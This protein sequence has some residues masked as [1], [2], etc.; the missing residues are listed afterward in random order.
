MHQRWDVS[1]LENEKG[2]KYIKQIEDNILLS[3]N[4]NVEEEWL[5]MKNI[6]TK[7][8]EENLGIRK[9]NTSKKPWVTSEMLKKMDE[10]KSWKN[11]KTPEGKRMYKKLNN[12]L[13]RETDK[14]RDKWITEQC[15]EIEKLNKM[16]RS[17]L[18]YAKAKELGKKYKTNKNRASSIKDKNGKLLK[19]PDE[20]K[21]R[22][23][24]YIEDLYD[25]HNKPTA[26]NLESFEEVCE[27]DRGLPILQSETNFSL[28]K[29]KHR[30]APALDNIP[31]E[32]LTCLGPNARRAFNKLDNNIYDSGHWPKEFCVSKVVTIPKKCNTKNCE[33][34]RTLSLIPHSSKIL[35]KTLY[36]RIYTKVET[37]LGNDQ[38]GFRRKM[39]TREAIATLRVIAEKTIEFGKS[40]YICFVD[41]EKAFDRVNWVKLMEVLKMI[42]L[43]WKERRAVWELYVNQSAV[44]Q[45]GD[46]LSEPAKIGRGARQGGLLSTIIFNI[47]VQFMINEALEDNDDGI[48]ISGECTPA[49]RFADD[50]AMTSHSNSGLQRIMNDLNAIGKMYGMKI[51][52]DKTKVMRITHT[53]QRHIKITIDGQKVEVVTEFKYLGSMITNDGRCTTE[54]NHRIGRAKAAFYEN[55]KLLTS[56]ADINMRK[57]FIK[58]VVWSNALY[59]AETWTLNKEHLM[60]LE[61]FEMW[62]WRHMLKIKWQDKVRNDQ[63]LTLAAEERKLIA[64]IRERQKRWIGHILRGDSLLKL[65]IE[66]RYIG[67]TKRGRKRTTLLSYLQQGES[68]F[69]LKRRAEDRNAWRCWT[70]HE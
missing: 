62:C 25:A 49:V 6:I 26:C 48:F 14:A 69:L 1:N 39:G 55:E 43:D 34:H 3:Q 16:G 58:T 15:N 40:L 52:Q 17:D 59:A 44:I 19:E 42:G 63:V 22:W 56:N 13:R 12:E 7:S 21:K 20:I 57:Q 37:F 9:A 28:A 65:A 54:I 32:L 47:Y 8:A 4:V 67:K 45:V 18:M 66:G 41:Y 31:G 35:L 68:Y 29:L 36:E 46:D 30:K 50:K 5:H 33:E 24:E 11:V 61:A 2:D 23:R 70:P 27:D 53:T 51:N 60:K 38:F 64:T 10:R